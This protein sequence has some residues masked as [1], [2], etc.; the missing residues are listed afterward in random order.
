MNNSEDITRSV[1]LTAPIIIM[2]ILYYE[3]GG[4]LQE[5]RL[6]KYIKRS[7]SQLSTDLRKLEKKKFILCEKNRGR[8]KIQI[9]QSGVNFI[10]KYSKNAV[11]ILITFFDFYSKLNRMDKKVEIGLIQ[12]VLREYLND[13][14]MITILDRLNDKYS[15]TRKILQKKEYYE[16]IYD[17]CEQG[18]V[19]DTL[20][21]KV[22]SFLQQNQGISKQSLF[23]KF[24]EAKCGTLSTLYR[25]W[26]NLTF[27]KYVKPHL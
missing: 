19:R 1:L 17:E 11:K 26:E 10:S 3:H 27:E 8:V 13:S 25:K 14:D 5:Q 18:I 21:H 6:I 20:I 2:A 15:K 16:T 23:Q 7:Y 24:P 22:F 12:I 9:T 4:E